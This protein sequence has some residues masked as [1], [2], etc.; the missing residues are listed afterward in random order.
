MDNDITLRI[1]QPAS[2]GAGL[3]RVDGRVVFVDGGLPGALVRARVTRETP[4]CLYAVAQETLEASPG[5]AEPF[6]PHFGECGGCTWQDAAYPAQLDWKTAIVAEQLR[7][8]GGLDV[9]VEP[10]LASPLERGYRNKMEFA[11]GPGGRTLLGLR[12]R[13]DPSRIVEVEHCA[14]MPEPAMAILAAARE[15]A[16]KTSLPCYLPRTGSGVWRHLVLRR[17]ELT[18]RW[19]VQLIVGP[20]TP[21]GRL[22]AMGEEL[23]KRFDVLDGVVL[24]VR[25]ERSDF[26]QAE[27][28]AWVLGKDNLEE[29]LNGLR[30]TVSADAFFQTN[31]RAAALLC[32]AAVQ[33]AELTG[34]ERV[35][36]LYCGVGSIT[37]HLARQAGRV[38]GYESVEAAVRDARTNARANA[39]ENCEFVAGDLKSAMGGHRPDV[40]VL[41][42]PRTGLH[43]DTPDALLRLAPARMVYV[44]CN[45]AT[46]AR[47]LK[48]LDAAYTVDRVAPVDMFPHTAHVEAVARLTRR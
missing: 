13:R 19:L 32:D 9:P 38:V 2:G 44:S 10:C 45:P 47:D 18:G 6:C 1:E 29:D 33:A 12:H 21:A 27:R 8:L 36:D 23:L 28:R 31:T 22:K 39:V 7:R 3:A 41:D 46:L 14:L 34:T 35:W 43:P 30:F 26:A 15:L 5:A 37:L 20:S 17:S 48:R 40:I 25:K 4:S 11:F 24:G 16:A 42:P